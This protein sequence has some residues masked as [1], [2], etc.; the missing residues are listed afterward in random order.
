[1]RARDYKKAADLAVQ[2]VRK[3]IYQG[4]ALG[5]KSLLEEFTAD[6]LEPELWVKIKL[7]CGQIYSHLQESDLAR[8][9]FEEAV[10]YLEMLPDSLAIRIL[11]AQVCRE[12]GFQLRSQA[13]AEA[14]TWLQRGLDKI[15]GAAPQHEADLQIQIGVV[16]RKLGNNPAALDALERALKLL[17]NIPS[18]LRL[19]ALLNLGIFHYYC[20]DRLQSSSYMEQAR[21]MADYLKDPFN[22]LAARANLASIKL[23]TGQW[24]AAF[25]YYREAVE[26]AQKVGNTRELIPLLM[27]W[28]ILYVQSGDIEQA[29]I[30]FS[31]S[32]DMARKA[33]RTESIALCLLHSADLKIVTSEL[34][35]A[36]SAL[37][38]ATPLV[39]DN[40]LEYQ[41][42][43]LNIVQARYYL[44]AGNFSQ[45]ST[46]AER[47]IDSAQ[48]LSM[49]EEEGQALRAL[50]QAQWKL[51]QNDKA[52]A[53]FEQ[54]LALLHDVPYEAA[55]TQVAWGQFYLGE[56]ANKQSNELLE[57]AYQAF[58]RLGAKRAVAEVEEL[59][60]TVA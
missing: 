11:W 26:L 20:K 38:E 52:L 12:L 55:R 44:A 53:A 19:L 58:T 46:H 45:A 6:H 60:K 13:P 4:R 59:L 17:P 27:N 3:Q 39:I 36:Y 18:R 47:A 24:Q 56:H 42:P 28:G 10:A 50:A 5:M 30:N 7:A 34:T 33:K 40:R 25:Q 41:R 54:S 51:G 2:D 43:F 48:R 14:L 32:L 23:V 16:Q 9:S 15:K 57:K 8:F 37:V 31:T 21:A 49:Q 1:L 29:S 22:S 35:A